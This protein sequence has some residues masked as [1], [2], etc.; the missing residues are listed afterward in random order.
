MIASWNVT[1]KCNLFCKHC[2]RDAGIQADNEL[3]TTEAKVLMVELVRAGFKMIIFSGGEPLMRPDIYE[4]TEY[5]ANLGLVPVFGS[6]GMLIT[7]EAAKRLKKSGAKSVGISIDSLD[8][9]KHDKFRGVSGAWRGAVNGMKNCREAGLKFQVHTTVMR[10]NSKEILDIADFAA[11]MGASA[12]YTFFLVPTGRGEGIEKQILHPEQYH[13][14]LKEI[15]LKQKE[16]KIV[17]KPT[18]APQFVRV[19]EEVDVKLRFSKG[20]LAGTSYCII[21][22]KGDV[23]P[24][25]YLSMPVGNVRESSFSEI[26]N[27]SSVLKDL[28]GLEYKGKCGNCDYKLKC[29]GCRARAALYHNGDYMESEDNCLY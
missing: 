19:A 29:G 25:A 1:N 23:Q 28:R 7:E 26:W 15:M 24:C 16:V 12:H 27:E 8:P 10:W 5:A 21:T 6:N 18:C 14:L 13:R 11:A 17:L 2:Y 20:C 9:K 4:L 3:T 22:P